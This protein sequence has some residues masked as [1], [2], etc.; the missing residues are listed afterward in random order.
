MLFGETAP[1]IAVRVFLVHY[2]TEKNHQGLGNE[3]DVPPEIDAEIETTECL[4]GLFRSY[5]DAA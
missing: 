3:L 2:H 1:R 4:G 5:R